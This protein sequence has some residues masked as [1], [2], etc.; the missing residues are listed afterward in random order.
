MKKTK[1]ASPLRVAY[2]IPLLRGRGGWPA[3]SI[4][5][6]RSLSGSVEP[7]LIVSRADEAAAHELFPGAE[8]HPLPEMQP[9][10]A[11]S[12]RTAAHMLPVWQALGRLPPLRVDLVHS[13]EMFPIGWVG[14][15][16]AV[17]EHAPHV[18]TAFGTFGV[19]WHRWPLIAGVYAGV[20]ERAACVCPMS[21]G[22]ADRM[23]EA[24]GR[25]LR[26]TT[27]E[28]VLNGTDSSR[29]VPHTA[30]ADKV[31]PDAP[32]VISVGALKPRKGYH[33][34]LRAFGEFQ[35]THPEA[36]Y[37]IVGGGT[38]LPYHRELLAI[39][40]RENIRNVEFPGL[41]SSQELD[42]LYRSASLLI[43]TCQEGG[44]HFEGFVFVFLEAGAYGLPVIGTRTGGIP[45]AVSDG[46]TGFLYA[47]D[48]VRGMADGMRRLTEDSELA[49]Q[50]GRNGRARAEE[51]TW[52]RYAAQQM[53]IY[54]RVLS[55]AAA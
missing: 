38:G 51:L 15:A 6:I 34:S 5:I 47:A 17:R 24:F 4:G 52:E 39:I 53:K 2:L 44:G 3:A 28:V 42:A 8:V 43:M 1:L 19:I 26:R 40:E 21:Q 41:L 13:L 54:S 20:L 31:F 55:A 36:R 12:L 29:R 33:V 48:D 22:T 27:V 10:T 37:V 11:G 32:L 23:R 35:R 50:M 18:L 16:L 30:A 46:H 25:A 9:M 45:D 49:R 14:D 7:V